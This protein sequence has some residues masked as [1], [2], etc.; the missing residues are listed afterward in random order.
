MN[1]YT[2]RI[3]LNTVAAGYITRIHEVAQIVEVYDDALVVRL[4]A[5]DE[6]D[7]AQTV[8]NLAT[9]LGSLGEHVSIERP[10]L[11]EADPQSEEGTGQENAEVLR[12]ARLQA[13]IA[14]L[15]SEVLLPE[16]QQVVQGMLEFADERLRINVGLMNVNQSLQKRIA[17]M[18]RGE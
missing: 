11:F 17:R 1:T 8:N 9:E 5:Q 6:Y 18:E 3:P 2:A 16:Q 4:S 7:L 12:D 15:D 13:A 14:L 10:V